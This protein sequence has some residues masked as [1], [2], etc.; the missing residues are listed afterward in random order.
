M[1]MILAKF[2]FFS[3]KKMLQQKKD[4]NANNYYSIVHHIR[5]VTCKLNFFH[6]AHYI[7]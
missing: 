2:Q 7:G 5:N 6:R 3:L 1:F 4:L